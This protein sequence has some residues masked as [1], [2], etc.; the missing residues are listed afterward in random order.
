MKYKIF[1]RNY[2][3]LYYLVVS[4]SRLSS[5]IYSI[6]SDGYIYSRSSSS[7]H[8]EILLC[9]WRPKRL[10]SLCVCFVF[11]R[12]SVVSDFCDPMDCSPPGS[13]VN[14]ISQARILEWVAN[15][16]SRGASRPRDRTHI[17]WLAGRFLKA[18]VSWFNRALFL[19]GIK[20][21]GIICHPFKS[22]L[23]QLYLQ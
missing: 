19:P 3:L 14:G 13:S 4:S 9:L 17:S 23:L 12:C 8:T 6:S 5:S 15:S 22:Q 11:V 20:I 7:L 10:T 21:L 16:S 1:W 18:P 2:Y